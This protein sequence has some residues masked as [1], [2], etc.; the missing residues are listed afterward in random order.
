MSFKSQES[1]PNT[2]LMEEAGLKSL[3]LCTLDHK[4]TFNKIFGGFI[5]RKAVL[6]IRIRRIR[7]LGLPDPDPLVTG[8]DLDPAPDPS[9]FS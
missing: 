2:V 8:T 3:I 1:L 5:M 6:G 9:L 4:N 7:M